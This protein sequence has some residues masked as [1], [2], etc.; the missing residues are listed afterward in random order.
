MSAGV[1]GM[2]EQIDRGQEQVQHYRSWNSVC[3]P[4]LGGGSQGMSSVVCCR[5]H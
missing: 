4:V 3:R 2:G 1:Q 5:C